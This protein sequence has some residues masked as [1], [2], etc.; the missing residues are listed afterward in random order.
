MDL[1]PPPVLITKTYGSQTA[2]FITAPHSA[3]FI[4]SSTVL[5]RPRIPAS[6]PCLPALLL[7]ALRSHS[8]IFTGV[9][10]LLQASSPLSQK[11]HEKERALGFAL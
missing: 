7:W 5:A 2:P 10:L 8:S 9:S 6:S 1:A 3:P 11:A 4:T